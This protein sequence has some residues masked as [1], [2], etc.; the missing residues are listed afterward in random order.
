MLQ[1]LL[2]RLNPPTLLWVKDSGY[3]EESVRYSTDTPIKIVVIFFT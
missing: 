2:P 1:I 3:P